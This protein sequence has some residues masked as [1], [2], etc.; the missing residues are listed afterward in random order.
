MATNY[1]V[2]GDPLEPSSGDM[3]AQ[4]KSLKVGERVP[5]GWRVLTGNSHESVIARVA[6]RYEVESE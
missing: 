4:T 1:L 5:E 2:T 6:L 3:I